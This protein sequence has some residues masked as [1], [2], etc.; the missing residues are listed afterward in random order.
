MR[1]KLK[2]NFFIYIKLDVNLNTVLMQTSLLT[3]FLI[4]LNQY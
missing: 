4:T 2:N 3:T 1:I